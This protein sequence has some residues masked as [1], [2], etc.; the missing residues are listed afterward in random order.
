MLVLD[1]PRK[2]RHRS[3]HIAS[4]RQQCCSEQAMFVVAEGRPYEI[5]P[6]GSLIFGTAENCDIRIANDADI[7]PKH[8]RIRFLGS[9]ILVELLD[10]GDIELNGGSTAR[11]RWVQPGDRFRF[12]AGGTEIAVVETMAEVRASETPDE[13]APAAI[14]IDA[15]HV[16]KSGGQ[17]RF[18]GVIAIAITLIAILVVA[19]QLGWFRGNVDVKRDEDMHLEQR[20]DPSAEVVPALTPV[21]VE[22]ARQGTVQ[23]GFEMGGEPFALCTGWAVN[24]TTVVTSAETVDSL[25]N[26]LQQGIIENLE[27]IFV[28]DA[29]DPPALYR[30]SKLQLHPLWQASEPESTQSMHHDIGLLKLTSNLPTSFEHDFDTVI[31]SDEL[32]VS[33][34]PRQETTLVSLDAPLEVQVISVTEPKREAARWGSPILRV[35]MQASLGIQG[36]PVWNSNRVVGTVTRYPGEYVVIVPNDRLEALLE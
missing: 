2:T 31:G 33:T 27:S 23:I 1:S 16:P 5:P 4:L 15:D 14:L 7:L 36:S 21:T 28:V 22:Q 26:Y 32:R 18:L 25:Q 34:V 8:A 3:H 12:T 20:D 29:A 13:S 6:K 9:R 35:E 11:V 17:W 24:P 30:V 19:E 10:E